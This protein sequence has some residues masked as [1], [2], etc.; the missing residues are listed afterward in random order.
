MWLQSIAIVAALLAVGAALAEWVHPAAAL[1]WLAGGFLLYAA[2]HLV[3][4]ARLSR[5]LAAPRPDEVPAGVFGVWSWVL[6]RLA[7]H[8]REQE[9]RRARVAGELDRVRSAVDRLPDA[10][11]VLDR[12]DHVVWANRAAEH[13]HGI[14]G[15]QMPIHHHVRQPDFLAYLQGEGPADGLRMQLAGRPGR[16]YELRLHPASDG[17]RLMI[18]RD[19]TEQ[20]H[21]DAMRR[22][23]VAN[24]SHEIR[25]PLTVISGFVETMLDV[26]LDE[27]TRRQYLET[28]LKQAG[29]MRQLV[30]DLLTLSSLEHGRPP[31]PDERIDLHALLS[32]QVADAR[33]LSAGRHEVS[34][35]LGEPRWLIGQPNELASAIRNLLT[36]AIRYT[37]AGGRIEVDLRLRDTE[38][39]LSVRD[40]GIGIPP[41]HVP[42]ITER[43][44][45]V[46][47]GRSRDMGGTGL[48]LAIVKHV[49]QRHQA[50]LSV[51]STLGAG[52]TF[53]VRLP[54]A[55]ITLD[56]AQARSAASD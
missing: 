26:P 33:A 29:T 38:A 27:A 13:L 10:L 36:N 55:R 15:V 21:V 44:Y 19:V 31:P 11:V 14:D 22:D 34:L 3:H 18:T 20:T 30:E 56:A 32:A 43:F 12:S 51:Q 53:T 25:T 54:A 39:C 28:I 35:A 49:L 9:E 52:S 45:R 47:R 4:L 23:F 2:W 41:E 48:G 8:E 1:A 5:W 46:D 17:Q 6:E 42:R 24:V 16:V 40:T 7:Q 50:H 37:P